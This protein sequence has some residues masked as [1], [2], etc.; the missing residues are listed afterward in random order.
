MRDQQLEKALTEIYNREQEFTKACT[1]EAE[2]EHAYKMKHAREFLQADGAVEQR[3]A[4]ALV[5][6]DVLYS[7]YLKKKAVKEFTKEKLRDSQDALSARQSL[8][9]YEI[10][11]NFG[12][13]AQT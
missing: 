13:T 4:T 11:T 2:A 6:C 8:L 5:A 10:K 7:D 1:E 3:K 12:Y 9:S